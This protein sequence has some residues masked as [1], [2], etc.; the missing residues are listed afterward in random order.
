MF[1]VSLKQDFIRIQISIINNTTHPVQKLVKFNELKK[2][3]NPTHIYDIY[4]QSK[5]K[6]AAEQ[7]YSKHLL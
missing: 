7:N 5:P 3:K 4:M 6:S 2:K 1:T